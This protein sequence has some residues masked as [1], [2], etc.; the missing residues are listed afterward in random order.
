MNRTE[1]EATEEEDFMEEYE[2]EKKVNNLADAEQYIFLRVEH[3][4]MDRDNIYEQ[5][6]QLKENVN[7]LFTVMRHRTLTKIFHEAD[8]MICEGIPA[9]INTTT[10]TMRDVLE[11]MIGDYLLRKAEKSLRRRLY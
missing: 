9:E 4:R 10:E 11:K 7:D 8:W 2:L 6:A 5:M 3:A 1:I